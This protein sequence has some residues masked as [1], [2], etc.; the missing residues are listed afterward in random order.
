MATSRILY[1]PTTDN[2]SYANFTDWKSQ[3]FTTTGAFKITRIDV[4]W[5]KNVSTGN[6]LL[7]LMAVDGSDK[8]TGSVLSTGS[9]TI[10]SLPADGSGDATARTTVTMSAYTLSATTKYCLRVRAETDGGSFGV[11]ALIAGAYAGG[12]FFTSANSGVDWSDI[13]W[14]MDFDIWGDDADVTILP[15]VATIDIEAPIPTIKT[16]VVV[17]PPKITI[18]IEIPIPTIITRGVKNQAKSTAIS[19]T[20]QTKHSISPTNQTK[21]SAISPTN[22]VKH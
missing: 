9:A 15:P 5:L 1:Q 18:N 16:E 14:D 17:L 4:K 3:V 10:A 11:R 8:P 20:N 19:P 21:S 7:E 2:T 22:Q 12:S 6:F 13:S